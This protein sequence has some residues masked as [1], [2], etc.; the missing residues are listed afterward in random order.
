MLEIRAQDIKFKGEIVSGM[1]S[2][3]SQIV[4]VNYLNIWLTD[5]LYVQGRPQEA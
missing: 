4:S 5:K 2:R 3:E 1:K